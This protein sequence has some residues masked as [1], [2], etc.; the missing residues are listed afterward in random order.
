MDR[1][2]A[3][4]IIID[5][6][7]DL[8]TLP[9]VIHK[10]LAFVGDESTS[11]KKL[12][13]LISYDQSI[14]SRLLKVANSA[15][16]GFMKQIATAQHAIVILGFK[17]VKSLVLGIA[18]F[19]TMKEASGETSLAQKEF[20]MHSMGSA[21]AGQIICKRVGRA[22]SET[23]F[24]A[25][26]LHDIGK[27]VLDIF[28]TQEYAKVLKN[29]RE[30]GVSM[31]EVEKEVM[32]FSHA[33]VGGWLGERWKLPPVLTS[34]ISFHHQVEKAGK[35]Y[36]HMTSI[37]HL[38]DI[39]CKRA[40]IGNSGDNKIPAYQRSAQKYLNL[41]ENDLDTLIEELKQEEDKAKSFLSAIQ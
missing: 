13:S 1:V 31:V 36:M 9:D 7:K 24:T 11:A 27:L 3:K 33:D 22:D 40:Q 4:N 6:V 38:A 12:G 34:P 2:K 8:P 16:Y 35:D 19:D 28:F 10:V 26:L 14:S 18:V 41:Q 37:V 15:Y 29:V 39:L 20:W 30:N 32:G 23:T 21:L 25:S 5:R 17:E